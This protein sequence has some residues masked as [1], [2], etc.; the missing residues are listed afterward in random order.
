MEERWLAAGRWQDAQHRALRPEHVFRRVLDVA[1]FWQIKRQAGQ[2]ARAPAGHRKSC[3]QIAQFGGR[4]GGQVVE[5]GVDQDVAV[6]KENAIVQRRCLPADLLVQHLRLFVE[7]E[8]AVGAAGI[9]ELR[10]AHLEF[11]VLVAGVGCR[12][13]IL[14]AVFLEDRGVGR[15]GN[16]RVRADLRSALELPTPK[17]GRQETSGCRGGRLGVRP[18]LGCKTKYG[19]DNNDDG[20]N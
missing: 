2:V 16:G 14:N 4:H 18:R 6:V 12:L 9:A 13:E 7:R 1:D 8:R 10:R 20:K 19:E 17:R 3:S 5:N 11:A 15:V